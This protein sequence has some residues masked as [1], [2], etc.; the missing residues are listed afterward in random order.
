MTPA[1]VAIHLSACKDSVGSA[2]TLGLWVFS[3]RYS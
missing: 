3:G 2:R 1:K